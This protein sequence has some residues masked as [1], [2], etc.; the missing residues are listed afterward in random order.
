MRKQRKTVEAGVKL[1]IVRIIKEH[2]LSVQH[3]SQNFDVGET[4]IWRWLTQYKSQVSGRP[5]IDKP[6]TI[7]QQRIRQLETENRQLRSEDDVLKKHRPSLP[8]N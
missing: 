2:G 5:G 7:D 1:E 3:V 6:L 8:G 4:A